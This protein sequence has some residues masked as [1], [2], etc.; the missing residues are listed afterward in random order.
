MVRTRSGREL[1]MN[2]INVGEGGAP[3][4]NL[5]DGNV[6]LSAETP[7]SASVCG[8]LRNGPLAPSDTFVLR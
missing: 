7:S 1:G 2:G 4:V 8:L 5:P 3:L 6:P